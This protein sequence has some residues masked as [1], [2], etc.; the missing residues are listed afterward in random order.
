MEALQACFTMISK[1]LKSAEEM[2]KLA[3]ETFAD[4]KGEK[5]EEAEEGAEE[6][7]EDKKNEE[8]HDEDKGLALILESSWSKGMEGLVVPGFYLNR[9][10]PLH[11]LKSELE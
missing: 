6:G 3:N 11:N 2:L 10:S 9:K 1:T 7:D 8:E 5:N 4:K